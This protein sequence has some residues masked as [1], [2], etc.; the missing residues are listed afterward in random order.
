MDL[1]LQLFKLVNGLAG[2]S[3]LVDQFFSL[4][5]DYGSLLF[6]LI[7]VWIWF[8]RKGDKVKNRYAVLFAV[9]IAVLA[10][11]VN[12]FIEF[13]YF[14]P[15]PFVSQTVTL[16]IEKSADSTSF[17]S[18]HSAGAFSIAF[19]LFWRWKKVGIVLLV[20]ACLLAFSR[21]FVGVHYPLDVISGGMI[22][23][24]AMLLVRWQHHLLQ[25][26][27]TWMTKMFNKVE[28]KVISRDV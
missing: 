8:T 14:R 13:I 23:L 12:Y 26:L 19:A 5:S 6:G 1:D 17:P 9:T 4:L 2:K 11:G 27:F 7:V 3:V 16:L 24:F 22:A 10:L 18:N 15:R 28:S 20:I 21:I 25:P